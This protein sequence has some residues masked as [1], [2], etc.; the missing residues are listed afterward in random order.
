MAMK[1]KKLRKECRRDWQYKNP[2]CAWC[3]YRHECA[4]AIVAV[5]N[6]YGL[7]NCPDEPELGNEPKCGAHRECLY[8]NK[9]KH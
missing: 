8:C 2:D 3:Y 5:K 7:S 1:P 4:G 6:Y 9:N